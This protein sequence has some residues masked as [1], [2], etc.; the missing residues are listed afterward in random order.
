MGASAHYSAHLPL[1]LGAGRPHLPV[2]LS[3]PASG[4]EEEP[5]G[6]RRPSAL[7][8]WS[9]PQDNCPLSSGQ[10]ERPCDFSRA[11]SEAGSDH[12]MGSVTDCH[13]L[14]NGAVCMTAG[15]VYSILCLSL[16]V[17][18]M[19]LLIKVTRIGY[20]QAPFSSEL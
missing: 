10:E 15:K 16:S 14:V 1:Q 13:L 11:L 20:F 19:E 17:Y 2:V 4:L 9:R 12:C 7:Q 5:D 18:E 8:P 6:A 3:A